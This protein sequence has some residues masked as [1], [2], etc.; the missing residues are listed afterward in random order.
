MMLSLLILFFNVICNFILNCVNNL[1]FL[2]LNEIIEDMAQNL[3]NAHGIEEFGHIALPS[4]VRNLDY[5]KKLYFKISF[6]I[7]SKQ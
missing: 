7:A 5:L 4:Q 3:Q 1:L 6:D 2:A